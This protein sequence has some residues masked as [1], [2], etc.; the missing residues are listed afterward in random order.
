MI[1]IFFILIKNYSYSS[2]TFELQ[3]NLQ[4]IQNIIR[5]KS[6]AIE[7][8]YKAGVLCH[9]LATENKKGYAKKAI[10][11]LEIY[12]II[13]PQD[14]LAQAYLGCSYI[15]HVENINFLYQILLIKKGFYYLDDA[16]QKDSIDPIIRFIRAISTYEIPRYFIRDRYASKDLS[17]LLNIIQESPNLYTFDFKN[18]IYYYAGRQ[19]LK[20]KNE[21]SIQYF[22]KAYLLFNN[23]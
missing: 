16:I 8:I 3:E 12:L 18:Q 11:F 23:L 13:K 1:F 15:M 22:E 7:H 21:S 14:V 10:N 9:D 20:Q 6:K 17:Y 2:S 19:A 5:I 4:E